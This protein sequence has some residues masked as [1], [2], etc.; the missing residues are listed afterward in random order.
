MPWVSRAD[1]QSEHNPFSPQLGVK[2]SQFSQVY[3][4]NGPFR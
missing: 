3:E 1:G 4:Q 2:I